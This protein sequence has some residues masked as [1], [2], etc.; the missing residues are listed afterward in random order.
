[1]AEGACHTVDT[2]RA[3]TDGAGRAG[4]E[5]AP[6]TADGSGRVDDTLRAMTDGAGRAGDDPVPAAADGSGRAGDAL[7]A[8][9][10]GAGRAGDDAMPAAVDGPDRV[11]ATLRAMTD[12]VIRAG[13]DAVPETADGSGRAGDA[14]RAITDGTGRADDN[15]LRAKTDGAGCSDD[16]KRA[17]AFGACLAFVANVAE[18]A[19]A[20]TA[21]A[22]VEEAIA[23]CAVVASGTGDGESAACRTAVAKRWSRAA[24]SPAAFELIGAATDA[25]R[26]AVMAG[27]ETVRNPPK[28]DSIGK[29][30]IRGFLSTSNRASCGRE[31]AWLRSACLAVPT[32][33]AVPALVSAIAARSRRDFV[34][35]PSTV[36][37][38][39]P[40]SRAACT[41][42]TER[43]A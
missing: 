22:P 18:C 2:S 23:D 12:G 28:C 30:D 33:A 24:L 43:L 29:L 35:T 6:A 14:L 40:S 39:S 38:S 5:A 26:F 1:M 10:D 13:N 21:R 36:E 25:I 42:L 4:D 11:G 19:D 27:A 34:C 7:R 37:R 31:A 16:A 9:I 20:R 41:L 3:K 17:F 15:A 32:A 8:M